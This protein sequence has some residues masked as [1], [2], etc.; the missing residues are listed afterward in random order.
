ME[1]REHGIADA[2]AASTIHHF[3]AHYV[4][5]GILVTAIDTEE[6]IINPKPIISDYGDILPFLYH[7]GDKDFVYD[8]LNAAKPLLVDGLYHRPGRPLLAQNHD[9]I[10]GLL[11]LYRMSGDRSILI[12]AEEAAHAVWTQFEYRGILLDYP[13]NF[14]SLKNAIG[15]AKAF[16]GGYIELFAGLFEYTGNAEYL[17]WATTYATA[18]AASSSFQ[19]HGLFER[20]LS[21][22]WPLVERLL[23]PWIKGRITL[24]KGNTNTLYGFLALTLVDNKPERW[25][26]V[27]G[28]WVSAFEKKLWNKGLVYLQL[29]GRLRPRQIHLKAA[30]A[31]LDLI[32][33]LIAKGIIPQDKIYLAVEIA[34]V[35]L[36][37]RWPNSLIPAQPGGETN[38]LDANV[39]M[40]VALA[41]LAFLTG[42][43]KY[44]QAALEMKDAVLK[45]HQTTYGYCN[46]VTRSGQVAD[47]RIF[48]KYQSLLLKLCLF[49]H[50]LQQMFSSSKLNALLQD[51]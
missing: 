28:Q 17:H 37:E 40:A 43:Q 2:R 45:H 3:H 30:F 51:R 24:F 34:E 8:L 12:V 31:S 15:H 21:V 9:W 44:W 5:D 14:G 7:F 41:R 39:D 35:W 48:V 25:H 13:H 36:S 20:R 4:R 6:R 26:T 1:I 27:I 33:Q 18:L 10:F 42:E 38:H 32:C 19:E 23:H 29:D 49:D 47:A 46:S 22:A 16:N 50:G 11:E